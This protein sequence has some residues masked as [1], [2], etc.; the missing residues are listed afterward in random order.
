MECVKRLIRSPPANQQDAIPLF[1][2]FASRQNDL[3]GSPIFKLREAPFVPV[4]RKR[5]L[6]ATHSS[7]KKSE[8]ATHISPRNCFLGTSSKFGDIFDFVDFGQQANA[9]L[10]SCG[11][12]SEPSKLEIAHEAASEPAR[13]L[14]VFQSSDKYLD[15]LRTLAVDLATLK[16]DKELWKKMK[17]SPFLL[18]SKEIS[19]P[20]EKL[21]D[22][23][24]EEGPIKHYQLAAP[25]EIIIL[26]DYIGFRLFKD[27][28]LVA[29]EEDLLEDFYKALGSRS[30]SELVSEDLKIGPQYEKQDGA[31]WLRKHVLERS[32]IFLHEYAK[33]SRDPIKHDAKWLEKNLTVV[34]VR[35]VAL[36]RT[37]K[38]TGQMHTEERSAASSK[39][40]NGWVLYVAQKSSRPDMYQVGQA[41]CQLI[42]NR[43]SQ[44]A[45]TFFEP[46]LKLELLDLRS[47]GYNVDRI[48]RAKAAEARI[49]EEE[50]RKALEEEQAR[51][52]ER[53]RQFQ[54]HQSQSSQV[55]AA[56]ERD[57]TPPPRNRMPGAFDSPDSPPESAPL[58]N[59]K[60]RGLFSTLSRR[61]GFEDAS[62]DK[63]DQ[64]D[65][66]L[67]PPRNG[68]NGES[69]KGP[70]QP[71]RPNQHDGDSGHVTNPAIIQQNLLNA[72][73]A[74][75]GH[76]SSS[77]FAPPT[78]TEVKEQA[79]Y[80][81]STPLAN[82]NFAAEA[83]NGT[84]FFVAKNL[85]VDL[86]SL[87]SGVHSHINAF[88]W[89][90]REVGEVYAIP[91]SA[92]HIFYDESGGTIAFNSSG[93]IFCNLRFF[94]QLHSSQFHNPK[95]KAE[96]AVWWWVVIAHELA[97]NIIQ[98][99]NADHSYYTESFIQEYFLKMVM[100][101]GEL[102]RS[103]ER[104]QPV[105]SAAGD[106]NAGAPPPYS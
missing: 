24:E 68:Q 69:S 39:T 27:R 26:D 11:A 48:L 64:L 33:Y 74:T 80:C 76:N 1:Q 40:A 73:Q 63:D 79:S 82:L 78:T 88:A 106:A 55:T 52:R 66:F 67:D 75:R 89:L 17:A 42:L 32:K 97:H 37:L 59:R 9:F 96:A 36:R 47:R 3:P 4:V 30:L 29:P 91:P 72:V 34:V 50:R 19:A 53:E 77:L 14:S 16:R 103:V 2:Y 62:S 21:V 93:S 100:K 20:K 87:L 70:V 22:V 5:D 8:I 92:L 13:L 84:R 51:I 12:K 43:P 45:Y 15:L 57:T 85:S 23:E 90:L 102:A 99:H 38:G 81:D 18:G 31:M 83:S 58:Q 65:K 71:P 104:E 35:S 86:S 41:I 46:F 94:L 25:N 54:Q 6:S 10:F 56:P 101:T 98:L 49:A 60:S 7:E 28:L 61:F 95:V 105:P 44:Q